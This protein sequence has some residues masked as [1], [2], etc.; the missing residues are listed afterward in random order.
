MIKNMSKQYRLFVAGII[1]PVFLFNLFFSSSDTSFQPNQ[2]SSG[3]VR[4]IYKALKETSLESYGIFG[5]ELVFPFSSDIELLKVGRGMASSNDLARAKASGA[6]NYIYEDGEVQTELIAPSDPY[7]TLDPANENKQW[8]LP[9]IRVTDAW[10]F[11]RGSSEVVVAV[12]D[13][14]IHAE[15]VE[16]NDGR[17]IAGYN[18]IS[19]TNIAA[20]SNSDDNGHG[21]AVAGVIAAT[22]DNDRGIAG[23]NWNARLMPLKALSADGTGFISDV[24]SAIVWAADNGAHIINLSM[25]GTGFAPDAA[26]N[27]A[28]RHAFRKNAVIVAAAGNDNAENG[29]NLDLNPV[30]PVCADGGENMVIGVGATDLSDIKTNFSNYGANCIDVMAPGKKILTTAYLPSDPSN[31]ILIYSSGTSVASPIVSGIASLLKSNSPHLSNVQIRDI[32]LKSA[33]NIDAVNTVGCNGGS[34]SGLLGKGRVNAFFALSPQPILDN[35]FIQ[36]GST[37]KIYRITGGKKQYVSEFVFAQRGFDHSLVVLEFGSQL[38]SIPD[39]D[40][41]PPLDGTLIKAAS[42][43]TVYYV[44]SGLRRP[45]TYTVFTTR[46]FR[47]IDVKTAPDADVGILKM[48]EWYWPP[49]GTMVIIKGDPTVYVMENEVKRPVTYFVFIQRK[50]S[51]SKVMNVTADEFRHI[52]S[53]SDRYWLAPLEGTLVKSNSDPTVYVVSG[54]ALRALSYEAFVRIGY[55]FSKIQTLPQAEIEVIAPGSPILN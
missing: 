32:I 8:Y 26:L 45:V 20:N 52:P 33:D 23:I 37:G 22:S 55:S 10:E 28:I 7:F 36:Q 13:T 14:G 48:G 46:N 41:L 9:K 6:F 1:L 35:A 16:L 25:G 34:C 49:D 3:P 4:I 30:Y 18:A 51:F 54:R 19:K 31:N 47:F 40:P 27:D 11:G 2:E 21:T 38:S 44:H 50:L 43:P 17:V 5:N 53:A 29:A 39:T 42:D 15:H 24:A 12:V